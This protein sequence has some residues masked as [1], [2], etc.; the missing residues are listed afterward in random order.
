MKKG[1]GRGFDSL[2][3]TEIIDDEFDP[4]HEEDERVS[5]IEDL[6]LVSVVPNPDQPRRHF[7]ET[8]LKALSGSIKEHG[9]LQPIVVVRAGDKYQIVA[10]ERRFR[11]SITAGRTHIPAIV[12]SV[13]DQ[14]QLELSLI[15]NIQREDLNPI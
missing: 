3:P 7:D 9:V 11:A 15:E 4:T 10:G 5:K 14:N 6:P 2:I 13:S 8:A 1:L 12:R